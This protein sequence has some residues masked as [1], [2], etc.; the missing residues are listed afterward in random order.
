MRLRDHGSL[1]PS[2]CR[3]APYEARIM[4]VSGHKE[5]DADGGTTMSI[6]VICGTDME[7]ARSTAMIYLLYPA[8]GQ[9]QNYVDV[10]IVS[11]MSKEIPSHVSVDVCR[12]RMSCIGKG[13]IDRLPTQ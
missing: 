5:L 8:A 10:K 2:M 13:D 4:P 11:C 12:Y 7:S 1:G 9:Q 6:S 3:I